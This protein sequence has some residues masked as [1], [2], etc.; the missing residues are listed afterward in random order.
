MGQYTCSQICLNL[1]SC[2]GLKCHHDLFCPS[3]ILHK[4]I[5]KKNTIIQVNSGGNIFTEGLVLYNT[6]NK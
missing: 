3:F 1:A 2:R 4:R 6:K 5:L